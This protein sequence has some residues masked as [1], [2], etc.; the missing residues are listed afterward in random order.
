VKFECEKKSLEFR[1]SSLKTAAKNQTTWVSAA[2]FSSAAYL[3]FYLFF[4]LS[5]R[6]FFVA[7]FW[8]WYATLARRFYTVQKL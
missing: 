6:F 5:L 3:S 1:G 4:S 7:A 8:A 2:S